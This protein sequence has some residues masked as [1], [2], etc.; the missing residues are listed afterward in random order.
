[1]GKRSTKGNKNIYQLSREEAGLTRAEASEA[2]EFVSESR[3]KKYESEKSPVQPDEVLAMEQAYKKLGLCNYYCSHECPIGQEYVPEVKVKGLEQIVLKTLAT[4]NS[5]DN[6]KNQL[7]EITSGGVISDDEMT[8]FARIEKD[9]EDLHVDIDGFLTFADFFFDGFIA[10]I[11][12]QSKISE[13]KRQVGEA[14]WIVEDIPYRL[15]KIN[16]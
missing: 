2:M 9:I 14:E 6:E 11:F 12:V 4:K 10:D 5:L 1:M 8:D 3:I 15:K 7:I 16:L 13:G